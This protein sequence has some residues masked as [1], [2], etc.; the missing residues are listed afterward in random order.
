MKTTISDIAKKAGVSKATVSRVINNKPEGV[1][2]K[3]RSR[4]QKIILETG[5]QPSGVARGLA[6]G[7]SRTIGLIIP[8]ITNPFYAQLVKGVEDIVNQ[9]GYGLF[10]CNSDRKI[11]KEKDFINLLIEKEVDGLILNSAES[12]CACQLELLKKNKIPFVLTDRIIESSSKNN[13]VYVDNLHGAKLAAEF[14]YAKSGCKLLFINGPMDLSQSKLRQ[15]GVE[16]VFRKKGLDA[17][18]LQIIYGDF[19]Q[20]SG[21]E[22]TRKVLSEYDFDRKHNKIPF[23]AVFTAND[24]MAIGAIR[25]LRQTGILIPEEVEVIGFDDIEFA[26]LLDP[27]LSTVFQP[28]SEMGARSAEMLLKIL[29][30]TNPR[31]KIITLMPEL[32]LRGT[33]RV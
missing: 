25:A 22:L 6:T 23:N 31:P 8:D 29:N 17:E 32:V 13:G 30:K 9:Y 7:K 18:K 16:E 24:I 28:S 15:A 20:E 26:R 21:Y 33:T 5:F 19:T 27:P 4:I 14:L 2:P 3:T 10:L 1:G 12:E 11:E